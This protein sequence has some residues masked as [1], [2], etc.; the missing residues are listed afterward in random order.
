MEDKITLSLI[1]AYSPAEAVMSAMQ[2]IVQSGKKPE[3]FIVPLM[4]V[5]RELSSLVELPELQ[6]PMMKV[7]G[8]KIEQVKEEKS[9]QDMISYI[10]FVF[11]TVGTSEEKKVAAKVISKFEEYVKTLG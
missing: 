4:M 9:N 2:G 5:F 1:A 3:D 11:E 6:H 10:K 8:E 7:E